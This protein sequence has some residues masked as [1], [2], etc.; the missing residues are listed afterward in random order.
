MHRGAAVRRIHV[1]GGESLTD[2]TNMADH[3][4]YDPDTDSWTKAESHVAPRHGIASAVIAN[5]WYV[6]GGAI[7]AGLRTP[8]SATGAVDVFEPK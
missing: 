3:Q 7:R 2:S 4:V 1:F 8:W 5:R 6:I